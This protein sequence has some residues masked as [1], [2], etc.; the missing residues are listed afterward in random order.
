MYSYNMD[1]W[2]KL[3]KKWKNKKC[4]LLCLYFIVKVWALPCWER[5]T[6]MIKSWETDRDV[7][8]QQPWLTRN[9]INCDFSPRFVSPLSS[10]WWKGKSM[11][12]NLYWS[13]HVSFMTESL[14]WCTVVIKSSGSHRASMCSVVW[15]VG[16][17]FVSETLRYLKLNTCI[18]H[19]NNKQKLTVSKIH[20]HKEFNTQ[21]KKKQ[22]RF[23]RQTH[24]SLVR[25][26]NYTCVNLQSCLNSLF[27]LCILNLCHA[28]VVSH[29]VMLCESMLSSVH[30]KNTS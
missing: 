25:K 3:F 21:E 14:L 17:I 22:V 4:M 8:L 7:S 18:L 28:T 1:P 23:H 12:I 30:P 24:Q 5:T 27:Y 2:I 16:Q 15:A 6:N 20:L 13:L 19:R 11:I 9:K 29:D 26:V 10:L